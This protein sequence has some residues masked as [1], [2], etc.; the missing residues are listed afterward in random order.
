[1]TTPD[2]D[3]DWEWVWEDESDDEAVEEELKAIPISD[4]GKDLDA[5]SAV[6]EST[7]NISNGGSVI[8]HKLEKVKD[9]ITKPE[10]KW[11]QLPSPTGSTRSSNAAVTGSVS[12]QVFD[13]L[14]SNFSSMNEPVLL[15]AGVEDGDPLALVK[16]ASAKQ[17][18]VISRKLTINFDDLEEQEAA[19][20]PTPTNATALTVPSITTTMSSP[21]PPRSPRSRRPATPD[22]F[23][24]TTVQQMRRICWQIKPWDVPTSKKTFAERQLFT[25]VLGSGWGVDCDE[26]HPRILVGDAASARYNLTSIVLITFKTC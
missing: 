6:S 14:N 13:F 25:A 8:E 3:R 21:S 16:V 12:I 15:Q 18:R 20:T 10:E 7:S 5:V 1:M 23:K 26:V 9:I 2:D 11:R 22:S 19:K 17:W 4:H 24:P